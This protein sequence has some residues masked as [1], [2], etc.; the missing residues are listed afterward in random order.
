M[1][2]NNLKNF[3]IKLLIGVTKGNEHFSLINF[4]LVKKT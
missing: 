2:Y 1:F 3:R 4:D